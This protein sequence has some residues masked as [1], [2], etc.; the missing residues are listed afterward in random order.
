MAASLDLN[1]LHE[2]LNL[3][4][5]A[6]TKQAAGTINGVLTDVQSIYF[7]DRILVTVSQSG[8]LAHW[9]HVPL[10]NQNPGTEGFHTFGNGEADDEL[11]PFSNL[12]ATSL[13]GGH[14]HGHEITNQ[15]LARQIGSAIATKTPNEKRVLVV[16]LGL[17][18]PQNERDTF[19]AIIDLVLQCI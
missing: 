17:D 10:E 7:S 9:L 13:L 5:P 3:P 11:L 6:E 14:A 2:V 8:R 12:S 4:F 15:L 19:F 16:G 18:R 1:S